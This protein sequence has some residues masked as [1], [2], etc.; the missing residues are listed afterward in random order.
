MFGRLAQTYTMLM[1]PLT[2]V[3]ARQFLTWY[4][5]SSRE[6]STDTCLQPFWLNT[7]RA[8]W[9]M[10]HKDWRLGRSTRRGVAKG[11]ITVP[12]KAIQ[13]WHSLGAY[14]NISLYLY[15]VSMQTLQPKEKS[16]CHDIPSVC[17]TRQSLGNVSHFPVFPVC[18]WF[19]I[20]L[21]LD[22]PEKPQELPFL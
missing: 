19:S 16:V 6:E 13:I 1:Q 18:C 3:K 20:T 22:A 10:E 14:R 9:L 7:R 2:Y 8:L 12:P 5:C 17:R 11:W 21:L 15:K 4:G